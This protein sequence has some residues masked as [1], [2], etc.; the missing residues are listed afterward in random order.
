MP[1]SGEEIQSKSKA[2]KP[3]FHPHGYESSH[4]SAFSLDV[5]LPAQRLNFYQS[6]GCKMLFAK[7]LICI[8]LIINESW[9]SFHVFTNNS[10]SSVKSLLISFTRYSIC[11][12]F[13]YWCVH[14]FFRDNCLS[15]VCIINIFSKFGACRSLNGEYFFIKVLFTNNKMHRC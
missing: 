8:F 13:S 2:T 14:N 15:D 1:R 5:L 12:Y 11:L 3:H 6:G 4:C 10:F 7:I 9:A